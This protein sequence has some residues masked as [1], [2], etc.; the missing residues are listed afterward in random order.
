MLLYIQDMEKYLY[1]AVILVSI[2]FSK[3]EIDWFKSIKNVVL[4]SDCCIVCKPVLTVQLNV[5][6]VYFASATYSL[7][8][9]VKSQIV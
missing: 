6:T 1:M 8:T 9:T 3:F 5:L 2:D 7:S 4:I